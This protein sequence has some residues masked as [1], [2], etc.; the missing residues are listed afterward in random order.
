[1]KTAIITLTRKGSKRFKNKMF[2]PLFGTPLYMHTI[3]HGLHLAKYLE[4]EYYFAHDFDDVA[5]HV[6][7]EIKR[8]NEYAGDIHKTCEE[9]KSFGIDADIY[10]L[11]QCT[12][13]IRDL[14][15]ILDAHKRIIQQ[16]DVV[17]I[18][19]G[20]IMKEGYYYAID[21]PLNFN[22][23]ERTDNGCKKVPVIKENGNFYVFKKSQLEKKH[24]LDISDGEK[25]DIAIDNID[26]DIDTY[27]DLVKLE[28]A[29]R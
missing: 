21:Q 20:K 14:S 11:L 29:V 1:M 13:P 17:A 8:K 15:A 6:P 5:Y 27:E 22:Q 7:H 12:Q 18:A 10:I 28:M 23:E 16:K 26:N 2:Y 3:A 19:S 24:I 25:F 9:I 4:C